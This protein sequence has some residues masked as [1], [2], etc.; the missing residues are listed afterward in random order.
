MTEPSK[1]KERAKER[2]DYV[3]RNIGKISSA[4]MAQHLGVTLSAI[5]NIRAGLRKKSA[6]AGTPVPSPTYSIK[7]A[8]P[9]TK[10]QLEQRKKERFA[11]PPGQLPWRAERMHGPVYVPAETSY[12]GQQKSTT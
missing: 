12:R 2:R 1:F 7:S 9:L 10:A 8:Q 4:S 11:Y 5:E 6:Q 3:E